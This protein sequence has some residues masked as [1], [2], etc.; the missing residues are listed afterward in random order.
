MKR[1]SLP[2]VA[3]IGAGVAGLGAAQSLRM[4][5]LEFD[6]FEARLRAGGRC[7][8]F[9]MNRTDS[10]DF[11]N[12]VSS[13]TDYSPEN[14][15]FVDCGASTIH[16]VGDED[17][18]VY[19]M[20][21]FDRIRAPVVAGM[22][23]YESLS[24]AAWFDTRGNRIDASIVAKVSMHYDR[25]KARTLAR[26][27]SMPDEEICSYN[28]SS[29]I[30][31]SLEEERMVLDNR[32]FRMFLKFLQKDLLYASVPQDTAIYRLSSGDVFNPAQ[33]SVA[34]ENAL[35]DRANTFLSRAKVRSINGPNEMVGDRIVIDGYGP[36]L[37]Q[38]LK[39]GLLIQYG[40]VIKKI[41]GSGM[42]GK[43]GVR[44]TS[45]NCELDRAKY[46][47]VILTVPLGVLVSQNKEASISISPGMSKEKSNALHSLG[48]GVHNKVLLRF[49]EEDVFWPE[50]VPQLNIEGSLHKKGM[51][52]ANFHAYG[53]TG[54]IVAHMFGWSWS[55]G[56]YAEKEDKAI[57]DEVLQVMY[58]SFTRND[59]EF[60]SR[61]LFS[62]KKWLKVR[63]K[64]L[65]APEKALVTR[66]E[67]DPFTLGSYSYVKPKEGNVS[68]F[69][70]GEKLG[71]TRDVLWL[72]GEHVSLPGWQCIHGALSSGID[73]AISVMKEHSIR[74]VRGDVVDYIR[75]GQY[76]EVKR[77]GTLDQPPSTEEFTLQ[78]GNASDLSNDESDERIELRCESARRNNEPM[79]TDQI[80]CAVE[81][82]PPAGELESNVAGRKLTVQSNR[83]VGESGTCEDALSAL[84]EKKRGRGENIRRS[85]TMK[86]Y[87]Q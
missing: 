18:I 52:F 62:K 8:S 50:F 85:I 23:T 84:E 37:I 30:Q 35:R 69:C 21:R 7:F 45:A 70:T 75:K 41:H 76:R 60:W 55:L 54:V 25:V 34:D 57:I 5:G 56:N 16:G 47:A 6:I 36:W 74:A 9:D 53:K 13:R 68:E 27:I 61:T 17:Q 29:E 32:E 49:K 65:P 4:Y 44:L 51:Q 38:R 15:L 81:V 42:K 33:R 19:E 26:P 79:D 2:R 43:P 64:R 67:R 24:Y 83:D 12:I 77:T 11:A 31:M 10:T 40:R 22:G 3:I 80:S 72:A 58:K 86:N 14:T 82:L 1:N 39:E 20:S 66:W 59:G 46:D 87:Q 63:R 78:E 28:V 73:A 71:T 48:M